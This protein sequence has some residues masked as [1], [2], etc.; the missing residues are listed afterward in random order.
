MP[1]CA[2]WCQAANHPLAMTE[3]RPDL[4]NPGPR[5]LPLH[6]ASAMLSS[7]S[8]VAMLPS[9][10][11][12]AFPWHPRLAADAVALAE[13][14]A[15]ADAIELQN[16]VTSEA[17][18]RLSAMMEGVRAYQQASRP[19]G[20]LDDRPEIW[21]AGGTRL[22]DY[23]GDGPAVLYVPSLVNRAQ[24]LDLNDR[25]SLMDWSRRHGVRPM[26]LDWGRP[27]AKERDL[28]LDDYILGRL[29]GAL[30]AANQVAGGPVKLVGYCMGGNLA[31]AAALRRP[32]LVSALALLAT[33]WDFHGDRAGPGGV[34]GA[35]LPGLEVIL[36]AFGEMPVDMLQILF[37][38]LDPNLAARKFR[39]FAGLDADDA[40]ARLF[41][42]LED[43]LNDGVPLVRHVA[44]DC[45]A[46]WYGANSTFRGEWMV[47]GEPVLPRNL[48]CPVL[49][50]IPSGDRIVPP[51]S[52]RALAVALPDPNIITPSAGHIG[53]MVGSRSEAELWKPLTEWLRNAGNPPVAG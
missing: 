42:D 48:Q 14:L 6:M 20:R 22:L 31:L 47:G 4:P 24:V 23:G 39:R 11:A 52:A 46:G 53:M 3:T 29:A 37:A 1:G 36:E 26:L 30:E 50:A 15:R 45:F 51:K 34:I 9:V 2:C 32:D 25:C 17:Q 12:G 7:L 18:A 27:G 49:L 5:P 44:R 41:V 8:A 16:A 19:P 33:P 40:E 10:R 28:T 38:A 35:M 43:W 13:R 21:S